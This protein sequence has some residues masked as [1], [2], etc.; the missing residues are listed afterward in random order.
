MPAE[1]QRS[2]A[3]CRSCPR[4]GRMSWRKLGVLVS[5]VKVGEGNL[6]ILNVALQISPGHCRFSDQAEAVSLRC[7]PV[8]VYHDLFVWCAFWSFKG[9]ELRD[10][11]CTCLCLVWHCSQSRYCL[12]SAFQY[13]YFDGQL[14]SAD[15][16]GNRASILV[17]RN[18]I[19][20]LKHDHRHCCIPVTALM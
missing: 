1:P 17:L 12:S 13:A 2:R 4:T 5:T 6:A 7:T 15:N 18:S 11:N 3:P 8:D 9:S 16:T 14:S 19:G 10:K 20:L